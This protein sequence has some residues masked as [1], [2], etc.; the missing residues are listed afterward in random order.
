[1]IEDAACA[2][3]TTYAG[4]PVGGHGDLGCF[5]FHPRKVITTGEGGMVT[6][7]SEAL[8]HRVASLRNHG[9]TGLSPEERGNPRNHSMATFDN[10]GYNLRLS[11]IQAAVGIAQ[12]A[13]LDRLLAE[14]R[15]RARSYTETLRSE[16]SI[17]VP[18]ADGTDIEGHAFQSYVVRL[19]DGAASRRNR[20]IDALQED[21]IQTRPGTHAVHRLGYYRNKYGLAADDFPVA[22][23]CE[24]TTITLPIFPGMTAEDQDRVVASLRRALRD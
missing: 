10:L 5:S 13:K 8:A 2:I 17:A 21:G 3:G 20:I 23:R 19:R 7:G 24:D 16:G 18:G 9:S 4:V 1:V 22:A 12:M 11:D 15:A 6:T 14:R